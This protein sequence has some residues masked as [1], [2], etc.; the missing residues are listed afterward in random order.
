MKDFFKLRE[1]LQTNESV[2][3][4]KSAVQDH[5][6]DADHVSSHGSQHV[7]QGT[8]PDR[9]THIYHVHDTNTN[10]TH[11]VELDHGGKT[12]SHGSVSKAAGKSV[13]AAAVKAVHSHHKSEMSQ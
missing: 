3:K 10:K 6:M 11:H 8:Q 2:D 12:M 1:E 4:A 5:D 13:S 9:G 7:F